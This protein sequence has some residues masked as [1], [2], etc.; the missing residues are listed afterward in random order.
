MFILLVTNV[1]FSAVCCRLIAPSLAPA[2]PH[3]GAES[4]SDHASAFSSRAKQL[5]RRMWWRDIK[6]RCLSLCRIRVSAYRR[7]TQDPNNSFGAL[8]KSSNASM[9]C[10]ITTTNSLVLRSEFHVFSGI[11]VKTFCQGG[12]GST[13][14]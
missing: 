11:R 5:H 7:M 6:V 1:L 12:G 8:Q 10:H 14:P 13:L 9:F 2:H 4:L 3:R